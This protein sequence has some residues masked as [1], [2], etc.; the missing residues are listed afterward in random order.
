M[1]KPEKNIELEKVILKGRKFS[2]AEL[3]G[4]EGGSF[5]KGESPVP[6]IVK[7][8]IEIKLFVSNNLK[9]LSY[10]LHYKPF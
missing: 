6:K 10:S 4:K 1:T 7:L 5:L 3:T 8:K 9:D 2:L